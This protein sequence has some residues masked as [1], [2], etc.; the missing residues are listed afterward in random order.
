HTEQAAGET[1]AQH[2]QDV[3]ADDLPAVGA[4]ALEDGDAAHLLQNEHARDAGHRDA[5]EN[6]DD[7]ADEAQVVFRAVEVA[8]DLILGR[9]VR[10]RVDEVVLEI[11]AQS[12][13]ERI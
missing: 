1:E 9:A 13:H 7:Q 2:L 3:D 11:V 5:A 6:D 12:A 4:D 10:P 8:T